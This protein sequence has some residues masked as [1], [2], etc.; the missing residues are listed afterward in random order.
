MLQIGITGL[1]LSHSQEVLHR[2]VFVG[3][4]KFQT[5]WPKKT[6]PLLYR[7]AGLPKKAPNPQ[8][9]GA[10]SPCKIPLAVWNVPTVMGECQGFGCYDA[11]F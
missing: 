6:D 10:R 3:I 1:L 11:K 8:V 7:L 9:A 4:I 5:S 2:S